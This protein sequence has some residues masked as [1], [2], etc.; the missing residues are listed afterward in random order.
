MNEPN[1]TPRLNDSEPPIAYLV[2]F[3]ERRERVINL[4]LYR[5]VSRFT[6]NAFLKCKKLEQAIPAG[7]ILH[8][9]MVKGDSHGDQEKALD[10][11]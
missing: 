5:K 6:Y 11:Q 3:N 7:I 1:Q 9:F 2:G 4:P 10:F 8:V